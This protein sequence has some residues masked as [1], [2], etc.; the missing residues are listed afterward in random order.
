MR[1]RGEGEISKADLRRTWPHHVGSPAD[2]LRGHMDSE[3]VRT[4]AAALS[5]A[6][7]A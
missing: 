6:P 7:L 1:W 2:K 4:A 5:A 3:I